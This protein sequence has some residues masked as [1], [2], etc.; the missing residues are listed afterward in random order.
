VT[1]SGDH[2]V[3]SRSGIPLFAAANLFVAVDAP[4]FVNCELHA[5]S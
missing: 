5:V 1:S 3:G 4:A 2:P